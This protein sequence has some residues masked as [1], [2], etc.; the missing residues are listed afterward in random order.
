MKNEENKNSQIGAKIRE[1][2]ESQKVSQLELAQALGY[3]SATAISLIESGSRKLKAEDL[4]KVSVFLHRD[5]KF[6]L[7]QEAKAPDIKFALRADKDLTEKD[8][9]SILDFIEFAKKKKDGRDN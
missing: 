2:R 6:F 9:S 3:E 4:E 7:G 5:V 8:V 1:A